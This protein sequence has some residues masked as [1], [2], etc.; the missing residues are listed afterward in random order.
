MNINGSVCHRTNEI[1]HFAKRYVEFFL[2]KLS[3]SKTLSVCCLERAFFSK[4]IEI[5]IQIEI[6]IW[7][8]QT[9]SAVNY[10]KI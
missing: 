8:L 9:H 1:I 5:D 3:P 6:E 2:F 4:K 7:Y 10:A